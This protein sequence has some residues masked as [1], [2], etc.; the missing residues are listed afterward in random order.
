MKYLIV[1]RSR[2][3]TLVQRSIFSVLAR[4]LSLATRSARRVRPLSATR[5]AKA[6]HLDRYRTVA[7]A[8]QYLEGWKLVERGER[9]GWLAVGEYVADEWFV[10]R[11]QRKPTGCWVDGLAYHKVFLHPQK[12]IRQCHI[13]SR[14]NGRRSARCI[15]RQVGCS[16]KTVRRHLCSKAGTELVKEPPVNEPPKKGIPKPESP[17]T[18]IQ[19]APEPQLTEGQWIAQHLI[20]DGFEPK[21]A[22]QIAIMICRSVT[23]GAGYA[24]VFDLL[25]KAKSKHDPQRGDFRRFFFGCVR[26]WQKRVNEP[27]RERLER[28][29]KAKECNRPILDSKEIYRDKRGRIF[30]FLNDV[31]M[32]VRREPWHSSEADGIG[33]VTT[34]DEMNLLWNSGRLRKQ[35]KQS[36][37]R[38]GF[39]RSFIG[40][41][42]MSYTQEVDGCYF[43]QGE[44][45]SEEVAVLDLPSLET[46]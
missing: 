24:I 45:G 35:K 42:G 8:L 6:L 27:E 23:A 39:P 3:L 38:R 17:Q 5:I 9:G 32:W 34:A 30:L 29:R 19:A 25:A 16:A 14:N 7:P 26:Q 37:K 33:E 40:S 2:K 4:E 41:D 31:A 10:R 1:V 11:K 46:S 18:D 13:E 44:F 36:P 12:T 22:K 21:W 15:A 28:I 20:K 43:R